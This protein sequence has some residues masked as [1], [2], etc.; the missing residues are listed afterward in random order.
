MATAKETVQSFLA[1]VFNNSDGLHPERMPDYIADDCVFHDAQPGLEGLKGY[2]AMIGMFEAATQT[3]EGAKQPLIVEQGDLV[4][5][6]WEHTFKHTGE[7]FGVPA[8]G[9]TVTAIG[10]ETYRVEDGKIVEAWQISDAA[11][12][13]A[14]LT[15]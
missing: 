9:R 7:L 12:L 5:I 11:G 1:A 15:A 10:H 8:T 3:I 6:R 4:S 13:M 14:Q 2:Q